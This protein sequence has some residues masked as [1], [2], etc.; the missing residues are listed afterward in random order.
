MR[1]KGHLKMKSFYIC[2]KPINKT[3]KKIINFFTGGKLEQTQKRFNY[4]DVFHLYLLITL[5]DGH[6]FGIDKNEIVK[7]R[8]YTNRDG[9]CKSGN[10]TKNMTFN[11]V[12]QKSEMNNKNLYI[13]DAKSYNCQDFVST[14]LKSAG[15][16][17]YKDFIYQDFR[18]AVSPFLSKISNFLTGSKALFNRI[19]KGEGDNNNNKIKKSLKFGNQYLMI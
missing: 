18:S 17:S 19:I 14:F 3:L 4:D 11:E 13:Y 6:K 7:I 16:N 9:E 1:S 5:E 10:F 2:R 12:I 15:I 8:K